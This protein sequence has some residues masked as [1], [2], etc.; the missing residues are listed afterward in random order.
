MRIAVNALAATR[1]GAVTMLRPFL[2]ALRRLEPDWQLS[3]YVASPKLNVSLD[4]FVT[5][6]VR[7]DGWRR[8]WLELVALERR[9]RRDGADLMLNLLN[10]GSL[11]PQVPSITWQRNSL[12]FDRGWL[13]QQPRRMRFEAALRRHV[14][15]LACR[16]SVATVT[17]SQAMA[18]CVRGWRLGANLRVEAIPHGVDT[19][20]F[21]TATN[22]RDDDRFTIGVMGHAAGHRG[23]AT[24]VRVLN[25]VRTLGVNAR[26]LFTVPRHGNPAFQG[27]VDDAARLAALLGLSD[28]VVFG[29]TAED[30]AAWYRCLDLL[31]IPSECESFCL[32]LVEGFA[33]SVPVV[34]S[35]LPVLR[36]IAG[37]LAL[38]GRTHV[39]MAAHVLEIHGENYDQRLHRQELARRRATDFSWEETAARTRALVVETLGSPRR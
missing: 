17:P 14:A 22:R 3:V 34:S 16:A 31:L 28:H 20:R 38:H 25:E 23:F 37:D 39:E 8:A 29:G 2:S 5:V 1:G 27:I 32:P 4:G 24:A 33:A 26:L 19:E 9:A 10:S 30:P 7:S 15:L 18:D 13:D 36:E 6:L 11:V 12:Y 35:G 21:A